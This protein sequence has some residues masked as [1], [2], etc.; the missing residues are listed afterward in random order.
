MGSLEMMDAAPLLG[1]NAATLEREMA[2]AGAVIDASIRLYFEQE[3][4]VGAVRAL[5]PP[6]LA[7]DASPY[8]A[9]LRAQGMDFDQR[10]ILILAMLTHLRPQLLDPF[11]IKN[12]HFERG[13]TEFGGVGASH[14]GFQPTLETAAFV[15]AGSDLERRLRLA[16]LFDHDHPFRRARLVE[17]DA[18]TARSGLFASVLG[19]HP[20]RLSALTSGLAYQPA[21]GPDFPAKRLHTPLEWDDLVLAD[22]VYDAVDEVCAWIEH[23]PELM[24]RWQLDK[25]V[26]PGFRA[27][28][29]GPPGTGKT[30]T[31]SLLG[32]RCGLDVYRVDLS[33]VVSKYIG[34]TEKNL[35]RV[36]DHAE[37]GQW[38]LFFDEAD[39]LFGKR[40]AGGG[41]NERYANQEVAYLLQRIEDFPGV[42]ILATNLKGNIDDAFARR[43]QSMIY[44]P[45]PGVEERLR[46]WR[47]A[48]A[49][50]GRLPDGLDLVPLAEEFD[51]SGG[52]IGN[53]LRHAALAALRAGA[54]A[55]SLA[56]MRAGARRE[57]RKEGKIV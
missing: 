49:Q 35:A 18:G 55:V 38:I 25:H 54:E 29:H 52:A 44:F 23:G 36:F 33:Q 40:T 26:K 32:K 24:R 27:L 45:A 15:L 39:A 43:F 53:V 42:V 30:L 57:L 7:G 31:A 10:F 28:F 47:G 8:A 41:V 21:F 4:T 6:D 9:L 5:A 22:S 3:C 12:T 37:G 34:E 1:A 11:L 20:E 46:L 16:H 19:V 48:F 51:L 50:Q 13:F 14:G 17:L 2:W 56:D